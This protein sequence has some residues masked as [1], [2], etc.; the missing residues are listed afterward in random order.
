MNN[1]YRFTS[2]V[3]PTIKELDLLMTEVKKEVLKRAKAADIKFANLQKE[4]SLKSNQ[5]QAE[6][7]QK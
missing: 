3:E 1:T 2:D 4:Y 5:R 6:K 7:S